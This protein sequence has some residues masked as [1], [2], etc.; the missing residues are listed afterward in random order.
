MQAARMEEWKIVRPA[1]D[2]PVE[3]YH[4][5]DDPAE[6]RDLA[7]KEPGRRSKLEEV[8]RAARTPPRRQTQ[9]AE[10]YWE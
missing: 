3:L 5:K 10:N 1:P 7:S 2:A 8:L 4:L 9:P 6:S